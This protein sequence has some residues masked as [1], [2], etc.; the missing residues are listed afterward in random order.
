VDPDAMIGLDQARLASYPE[1]Y[2]HL[3]Y[4][5]EA[6]GYKVKRDMPQLKGEA[7]ERLYAMGRNWLAGGPVT[8]M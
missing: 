3:A 4:A 7:V 6:I 1:G 2:R 5:Q 8:P